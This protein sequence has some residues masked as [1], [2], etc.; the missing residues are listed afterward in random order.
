MTPQSNYEQARDE[1]A[2]AVKVYSQGLSPHQKEIWIDGSDFGRS[3]EQKQ[4]AQ[5]IAELEKELIDL[6][7]KMAG[8]CGAT[9]G[10]KT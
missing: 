8:V 9:E 7:V 4:S 10:D 1:A 2:E 6:K 3:Y 5:K